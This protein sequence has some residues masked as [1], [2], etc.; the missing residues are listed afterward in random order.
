[1]EEH[2]NEKRLETDVSYRLTMSLN[3][4]RLSGIAF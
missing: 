1:M 2:V 4:A 3:L